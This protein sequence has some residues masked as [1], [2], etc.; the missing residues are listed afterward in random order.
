M[1]LYG[2]VDE[3]RAM[4]RKL[5]GMHGTPCGA[6]GL[7]LLHGSR[8]SGKTAL[9]DHLVNSARRA[10]FDVVHDSAARRSRLL[11]ALSFTAGT[12]GTHPFPGAPEEAVAVPGPSLL[13]EALG[14]ELPGPRRAAA[15][16]VLVAVD[17]VAWDA[18]E[19]SAA[20]RALPAVR[21]ERRVLW[22]LA[23]SAGPVPSP[24]IRHPEVVSLALGP[25]CPRDALRM[26]ADRLG[27]APDAAVEHLVDACGGHPGLLDAVLGELVACAG[28]RARG[29]VA[30]PAPA[31]VAALVRA[32]PRLTTP[33]RDFLGA[34]AARQLPQ[35]PA[36]LARLPEGAALRALRCAHEAVEAG[37]LV[38]DG[39]RLRFRH[40]L[41]EQ[42]AG[43]LQQRVAEDDPGR[44][45]LSPTEQTITRL[46][47]AGLTNRQIASRV[48]LSPHTV[49]F[50]LRKIFQKLGVSSRVELVGTR[51]HLVRPA[52]DA[53]PKPSTLESRPAHAG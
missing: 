6:N 30:G 17:D 5:H 42:A 22:L 19:V 33:T 34:F 43:L 9:L 48:N 7:I 10:G 26:A 4:S 11:W 23:G 46:V 38:F 15:R 41:L 13:D 29:G 3:Q 31:V 39:D 52:F 35:R 47:A 51:L 2:R 44:G 20:L 32:D 50:H 27:G 18:P 36:E 12:S 21:S 14:V 49:N 24:Q 45:L 1:D 16:P 28:H 37:V 53:G 8:G 25:L 40:P